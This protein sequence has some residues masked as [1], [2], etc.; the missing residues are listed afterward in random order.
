MRV[1]DQSRRFRRP[2]LCLVRVVGSKKNK[3]EISEIPGQSSSESVN[4]VSSSIILSSSADGG[5]HSA[6]S[7]FFSVSCLPAPKTHIRSV[8]EVRQLVCGVRPAPPTWS[9][10]PHSALRN[11][12]HLGLSRLDHLFGLHRLRG[13][14]FLENTWHHLASLGWL[15][16]VALRLVMLAETMAFRWI[17]THHPTIVPVMEL[18]TGIQYSE[19]GVV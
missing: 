14:K 12:W 3:G 9:L 16:P 7:L 19:S 8:S 15:S 13:A 18:E 2:H 17:C 1:Q 6:H 4:L 10:P 5:A 11:H